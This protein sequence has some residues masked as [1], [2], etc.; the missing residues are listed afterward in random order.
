MKT[1]LLAATAVIALASSATAATIYGNSASSGPNPIHTLNGT[2]GVETARFNGQLG[3]NGRGVVVVGN[4]IYYT[5]VGDSKIYTMDRTSGLNT[6]FIQTSNSSMATLAWDGTQFW[7]ADYSGSNKAFR[8][9]LAGV[10]TSTIT[11]ANATGNMDGLEWF[12]GKLIGNR[13]DAGGIYDIYDLSGNILTANFIT[14]AGSSTGIAY[15]GA[16]FVVSNVFGSSLSYFNGT[17]GAFINTVNLTSSAGGFL[18]EDLSVD[19]AARPDTGGAVPEPATWAMM[20]AG[21][22]MIGGAMRHRRGMTAL[23][24]I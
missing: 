3:A 17:T 14:S 20:L 12:N 6:G 5:V 21:F 16:N 19:Y 11:L 4:I 1:F 9:N 8:I 13:S 2:T 24:R 15:D 18:I 10:N 22:G 23:S 7:T